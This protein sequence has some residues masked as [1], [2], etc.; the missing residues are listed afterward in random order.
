MIGVWFAGAIVGHDLVLY[1]LYALLDGA[2]SR[3]GRRGPRP[4]AVNFVR[5][6][7]VL[8]GL[9]LLVAFPLVLGLNRRTYEEASGRSVQP[10][11][12]RWL[13]FT[14]LVF[15]ASTLLY[16]WRLLRHG[17]VSTGDGGRA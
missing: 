3:L 4:S 13:L 15:L 12:G 10:Y 7:T 1:P 11:L 6:P 2:A 16:V 9:V 5:V 8:S 14:G 17:R